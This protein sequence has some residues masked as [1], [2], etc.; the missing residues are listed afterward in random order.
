MCHPLVTKWIQLF[1]PSLQQH[2]TIKDEH[3]LLGSAL[4]L[5]SKTFLISPADVFPS[6]PHDLALNLIIPDIFRHSSGG[7]VC[8]PV[9]V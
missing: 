1:Q 5:G 9:G 8:E 3:V 4:S 7:E 6:D 2:L